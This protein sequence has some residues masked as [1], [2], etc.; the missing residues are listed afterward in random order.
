MPKLFSVFK[1]VKHKSGRFFIL[2]S[3][4]FEARFILLGRFW[5]DG[6]FNFVGFSDGFNLISRSAFWKA[7]LFAGMPSERAKPI[8]LNAHLKEKALY[9]YIALNS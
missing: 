4:I 3:R 8:S 2:L 9:L 5:E 1:Q 6:Q 7:F